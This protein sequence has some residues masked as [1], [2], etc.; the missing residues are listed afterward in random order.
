MSQTD[1]T[2]ADNS[3]TLTTAVASQAA[4]D[5]ELSGTAP[6]SGTVGTDVT[7]TLTATN[8]GTATA[9]GVTLVD[10][11]PSGVRFVSATGGVMPV[12]GV[13]TFAIGNLAA[14][15]DVRFTVVVAPTVA[16]MLTD[17][18]GVSLN[19]VD[20]TP[21]DNSITLTTAIASVQRMGIHGQP[22][23]LVL[24]FGAPVDAGWAQNTGN[25]DL[26]RLGGSHRTIRFKSAVYDAAT[27]TVTLRPVR[28]LNLHDLFRLTVLDPGT[29]GQTDPPGDLPNSSKTTADR[30][31]RFV[32]IISAAELVLTTRN[33]AILR[34]YRKI[35][36][37]QSAQLKRLQTPE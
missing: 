25:Y 9:T 1:P 33:P 5:L 2:P 31:S 30:D 7:Y 34:A 28:R 36:L 19:Q 3:V 12:D 15:A 4:P 24:R 6:G 35:L 32:A 37:D 18:A 8:N 14:G 27:R 17:T 20:P 11:L 29:S 10:T 22:T 26:V 23:T 21:G 13:L 16:G